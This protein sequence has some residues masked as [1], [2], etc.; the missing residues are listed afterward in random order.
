M[1][2]FECRVEGGGAGAV[3]ERGRKRSRGL[4]KVKRITGSQEL[5]QRGKSAGGTGIEA[6][7]KLPK[8]ARK[9]QQGDRESD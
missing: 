9:L 3:G 7:G 4:K 8:P 1:R 6:Q 2:S 5:V